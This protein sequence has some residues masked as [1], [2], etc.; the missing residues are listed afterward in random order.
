VYPYALA[1]QC[2]SIAIGDATDCNL[3]KGVAS[4]PEMRSHLHLAAFSAVK[5]VEVVGMQCFQSFTHTYSEYPDEC[6]GNQMKSCNEAS[7]QC[8]CCDIALHFLEAMSKYIKALA[9]RQ[10]EQGFPFSSAPRPP[11]CPRPCKPPSW[12]CCSHCF[13]ISHCLL[14]SPGW[15]KVWLQTLPRPIRG[16]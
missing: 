6:S 4:G 13:T 11:R 9:K 12:T 1:G 2:W 7:M 5:S 15:F 10:F 14:A 3:A 8:N 16:V